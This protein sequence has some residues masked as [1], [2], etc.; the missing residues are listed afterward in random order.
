MITAY[1]GTA[2]RCARSSLSTP[3]H[4]AVPAARLWGV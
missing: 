2:D 3:L 1:Q 4:L